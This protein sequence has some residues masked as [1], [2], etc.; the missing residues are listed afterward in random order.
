MKSQSAIAI[1]TGGASG[2]GAAIAERFASEGDRDMVTDMDALG[3]AA[4][5]LR[6]G[7]GAVGVQVDLGP[8]RFVW[9]G[10]G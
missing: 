3:A 4:R 8:E 5:R 9:L 1:V 10:G 2:V 7:G 6:L